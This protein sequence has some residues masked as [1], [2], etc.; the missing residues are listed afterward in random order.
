MCIRDRSK[1]LTDFADIMPGLSALKHARKHLKS[2]MRADKRG[3]EFP[4]GLLGAKAEV[5]STP[6][7]T[8]GIMAPWNFP[9]GMV[10]VRL[11]AP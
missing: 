2:W 10:F 4:L 1:D 7:G 3:V 9:V 5:R 8:V 11:P 6:K